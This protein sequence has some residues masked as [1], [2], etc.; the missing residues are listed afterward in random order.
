[1]QKVA[2]ILAGILLLG[3]GIAIGWFAAQRTYAPTGSSASGKPALYFRPSDPEI[4]APPP[5]WETWKYPSSKVDNSGTGGHHSVGEL[6]FSATERIALVTP[7]DFDQVWSWYKENCRLQGL[8]VAST[9]HRLEG[10]GDQHSMTFKIFDD[11]Q[12]H[13]FAGP[14]SESLSARGFTVQSLRYTL[15]GFVYRQQGADA[16]CILLAYR[17]N[18]EL[19]GL[20]KDRLV[21]E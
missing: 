19:I 8:G 14:K 11:I 3:V 13:S 4:L 16:T 10:G 7:D 9:T 1:M 6:Q 12:A 20:L 15:V 2:F 18:T 21:K 17:P 5:P